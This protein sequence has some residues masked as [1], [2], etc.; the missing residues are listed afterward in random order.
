MHL[1]FDRTAKQENRKQGKE[2]EGVKCSKV[3]QGGIELHDDAASVCMAL[4]L[5]AE[6]LGRP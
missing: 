6:L 5:P 4:T 3:P 2:R 1:F